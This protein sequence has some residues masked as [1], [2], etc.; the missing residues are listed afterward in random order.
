MVDTCMAL[1]QILSLLKMQMLSKPVLSFEIT[2]FVG[3]KKFFWVRLD[4]KMK[5]VVLVLVDSP[6]IL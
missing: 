6:I 5:D 4:T 2:F 3:S 1:S